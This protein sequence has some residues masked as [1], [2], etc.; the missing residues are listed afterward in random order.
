[1]KNYARRV[2]ISVTSARDWKPQ[3]GISL[4]M[5]AAYTQLHGGSLQLVEIGMRGSTSQSLLSAA[6]AAHLK[7]AVEGNYTHWATFDD[8]MGFPPDTLIQLMAHDKD[9]VC[10]NVCQK[11][12]ARVNGV[13]IGFDGKRINS[14]GRTG[15]ETI[16]LATLAC[17][18]M[19]VGTFVD[20]PQ[21]HFEIEWCPEIENYRG[22]DHCFMNKLAARGVEFWCDHDLTKKVYHVGDYPYQFDR[23]P[24]LPDEIELPVGCAGQ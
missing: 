1:M 4:A 7:T 17:T 22:E 9:F 19:K 2:L 15:L 21:P 14:K 3:F 16:K 8:D 11:I 12:A 23:M 20:L 10:A 6:R 18:V 13:C 24:V 5:M